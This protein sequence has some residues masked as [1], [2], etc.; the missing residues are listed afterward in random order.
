MNPQVTSK[1][2]VKIANSM[3]QMYTKRISKG[4]KEKV[5][6]NRCKS[7]VTQQSV[8]M[9]FV[10]IFQHHFQSDVRRSQQKSSTLANSITPVHSKQKYQKSQAK[11][12]W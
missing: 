11:E 7:K 4:H 3:T 9:H 12:Y 8:N 2:A 10:E 5:E 1:K 6:S